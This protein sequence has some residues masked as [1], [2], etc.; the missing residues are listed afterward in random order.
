VQ[1]TEKFVAHR[2]RFK[3]KV[4]STE[5]FIHN[6]FN[7]PVPCTCL[8]LPTYFLQIFRGSAAL[9]KVQHTANFAAHKNRQTTGAAHRNICSKQKQANKRCSAPPIFVDKR[10]Q[11]NKRCS[12]PKNPFTTLLILRCPAPCL[13]PP[14]Y[15]LQ[16]FRGAAALKNRCIAPPIFVVHKNK[17]TTGAAHRHICS[18][19]TTG[20]QKVQRT[21]TF[22]VHKN[23]LTK[24]AA[25]RNIHSQPF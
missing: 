24:G 17:R 13:L 8:L 15:F 23:S 5:T 12:A 4:Q 10:N 6:P 11:F 2:I 21:E 3:Q 22:V 1:S 25:H 9:K 7:I 14:T 20:E 19:T 18:T 16:I